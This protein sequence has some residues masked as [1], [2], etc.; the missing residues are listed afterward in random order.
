MRHATLF[1]VFAVTGVALSLF[2]GGC[3][4]VEE[5]PVKAGP[6][7]RIVTLERTYA[8]TEECGKL[9]SAPP[10][11]KIV[12]CATLGEAVCK[13]IAQPTA[14]DDVLGHEVRHCFDGTWHR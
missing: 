10:G 7:V 4:S 12:A 5:R 9:T 14:D 11:W 2:L 6:E 8:A 1:I 13:I 3:A